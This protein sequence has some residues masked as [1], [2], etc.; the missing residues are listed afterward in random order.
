MARRLRKQKGSEMPATIGKA[1]HAILRSHDEI[2]E[3]HG[4]LY[5]ACGTAWLG[6]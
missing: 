4:G 6:N 5:E 3:G 2:E 1:I